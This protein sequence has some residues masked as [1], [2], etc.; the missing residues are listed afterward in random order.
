MH[1]DSKLG[2]PDMDYSEHVGTYKMFCGV[3]LWSTVVILATVA[4]M[5]FFLT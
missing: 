1:I 3:V 4:G 5:A 2:H